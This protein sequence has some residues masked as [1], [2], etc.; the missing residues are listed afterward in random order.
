M[1][2]QG[3]RPSGAWHACSDGLRLGVDDSQVPQTG[4]PG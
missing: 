4:L 2:R 1:E 3:E